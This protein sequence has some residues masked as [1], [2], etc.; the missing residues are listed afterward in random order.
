M[1]ENITL[2]SFVY[3]RSAPTKLEPSARELKQKESNCLKKQ[4]EL[5]KYK[6]KADVGYSG[7][8]AITLLRDLN[9]VDYYK[10]IISK[11]LTNS[12]KLSGLLNKSLFIFQHFSTQF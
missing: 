1:S 8:N 5:V 11:C 12:F 7:S 3:D 2:S 10:K 6:V 9:G 4:L